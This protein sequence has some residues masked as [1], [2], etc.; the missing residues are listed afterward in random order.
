MTKFFG[1]VGY[2]I[3][4]EKSPGI[5]EDVMTELSAYGDVKRNARTL[6]QGPSVNDDLTV[7]NSISIVMD[8]YSSEH[9]HAIRYV[10]W[11]GALWRV[12]E[13]TVQR[14]RLLLRLGGV[15]NG[16]TPDPDTP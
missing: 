9:F 6:V 7:N 2:G 4:T 15:Y 14:P 5:W 13:V 1:V 12:T 10:S 3:A 16:P 11:E 8:A